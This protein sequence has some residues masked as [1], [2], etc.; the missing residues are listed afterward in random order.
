MVTPEYEDGRVVSTIYL[1]EGSVNDVIRTN[2]VGFGH[3]RFRGFEDY[4]REDY[5][6]YVIHR[7]KCAARHRT[8]T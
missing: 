7:R 1:T 8:S 3:I 6:G 5:P 2:T 4:D